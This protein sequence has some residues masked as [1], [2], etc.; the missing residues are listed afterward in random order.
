[1]Q[2]AWLQNHTHPI[3]CHILKGYNCA[4]FDDASQNCPSELFFHRLKGYFLTFYANLCRCTIKIQLIVKKVPIKTPEIAKKKC[5]EGQFW[6][7]SSKPA[8]L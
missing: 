5:S 1:V 3:Y 8:Q 2:Y 6:E 4:S 7:A